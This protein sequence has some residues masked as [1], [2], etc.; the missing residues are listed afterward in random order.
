MFTTQNISA[1]PY[2]LVWMAGRSLAND[3]TTESNHNLLFL[4]CLV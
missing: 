4:T 3:L 2:K 1:V